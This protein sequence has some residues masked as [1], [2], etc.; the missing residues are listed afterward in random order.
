MC[1]VWNTPLITYMSFFWK[2]HSLNIHCSVIQPPPI[3]IYIYIYKCVYVCERERER[4]KG[5]E[6]ERER[7]GFRKY[8]DWNCIYKDRKLINKWNN[9][10]QIAPLAFSALIPASFP[11]FDAPFDIILSYKLIGCVPRIHLN[12]KFVCLKY[13]NIPLPISF[14]QTLITRKFRQLHKHGNLGD[15]TYTEI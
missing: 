3:Y 6:R 5:R 2:R 9:F 12:F 14:D 7:V 1:K 13:L 4:E 8:L 15:C 11:L 10:L